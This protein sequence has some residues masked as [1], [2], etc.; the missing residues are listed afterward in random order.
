MKDDRLLLLA[1]E[2]DEVPL[3]SALSQSAILRPADIAYDRR[4]RRLVLMLSRYRWEAPGTRVRTA[5]RIES[6]TAVRR[7]NWPAWSDSNAHDPGVTML[8]LL[9]FTFEDGFITLDFAGGAALRVAV[10]CPD[11]ILEDLSPP[12]RA[13]RTPK[14]D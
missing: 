9:A 2:P 11:L 10:E 6:V 14:H 8:E 3:L 5:L 1:Q 7:R 13:A 12:W 4:A